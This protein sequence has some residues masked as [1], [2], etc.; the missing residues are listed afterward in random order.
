MEWAEWHY[1]P[2][3]DDKAIRF[4][5][6]ECRRCQKDGFEDIECQGIEHVDKC[7]TGKVK[8]LDPRLECFLWHFHRIWPGLMQ[9]DGGYNY[10][11]IKYVFDLYEVPP[12]VRKIWHDR[13]IIIISVINSIRAEKHKR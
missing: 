1:P 8:T 6:K 13:I 10:D 4:D 3:I 11:A 2:V 12:G 7:P 9:G 5:C